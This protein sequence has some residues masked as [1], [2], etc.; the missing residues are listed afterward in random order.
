MSARLYVVNLV[1]GLL[2]QSR[3][4]GIRR[5]LYRSAGVH[6]SKNVRLNGGVMIQNPN[7][8]VGEGT[9][10]GRRTEFAATSRS[11]ITIGSSCDVSQDVLFIT[12]SHDIGGSERRAGASD[13]SLPIEVGDGSWIGARVTMLGGASIGKG[14]VVAAS[15]LVRDVFPDNVLIA[16]TPAKIIRY[17]E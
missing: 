10:I 6:L 13:Q 9:W 11:S 15:S 7:V 8:R 2:P 14:V 12:G 4:F 3:A 1:S 5:A 17:L 16:G